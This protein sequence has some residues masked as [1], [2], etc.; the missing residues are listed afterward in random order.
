MGNIAKTASECFEWVDDIP[1][2]DGSF[3]KSYSEESYEGYF[4]E[5]DVQYPEKLHNCHMI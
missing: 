1:E 4:I 3:I 5:G 2:F